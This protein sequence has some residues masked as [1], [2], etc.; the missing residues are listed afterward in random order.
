MIS[1]LIATFIVLMIIVASFDVVPIFR[2]WLSRIGIGRF[3]DRNQWK[4]KLLKKGTAWL[5]KTPKMKVTDQTRL[6]ILDKLRGNYSKS[7]IQHWQEA[8]LILGLLKE[9][10]NNQDN[11]VQR[12]LNQFL[13]RTFNPSGDWKKRPIHIDG[14]MLAY[15][16]MKY[17]SEG[18]FKKAYDY[19][20]TLI[21]DHIGEDQTVGYRKSMIDYRYVDTIGFICP[22]LVCYGLRYGKAEC[23]QLAVRQIKE[24]S[25]YGMLQKPFLPCHAYQISSKLP[26]GIYGWGRGLAWYA[27]GLLDTW[28]ELPNDYSEKKEIGELLERLATSCKDLQ[29]QDGSWGWV[30]T[31]SEARA[32]SSVTAVMAWFLAN[33]RSGSHH[34][35]HQVKKALAYLQAVTRKNGEVDFSQGDTKDIGVYSQLFNVMPFTQGF[36]IRAQS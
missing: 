34:A 22:F 3:T 30:V 1:Y 16:A 29:K 15:A 18:K 11:S 9:M 8:A 12:E 10:N 6:V 14:A 5:N 19:M 17:D 21:K 2:D 4:N 24:F 35:D 31:R 23:V 27:I 20:W 36:T 26:M 32:D 13:L 28:L 33:Y 7:T 25:H